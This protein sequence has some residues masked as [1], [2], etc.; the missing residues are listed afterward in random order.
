VTPFDARAELDAAREVLRREN[1]EGDPL[2]AARHFSA[3]VDGILRRTFEPGPPGV[4]LIALGGYG[5]E[6]LAPFSDIDILILRAPDAETAP[7]EAFVRRLWDMRLEPSTVVRTI[8]ETFAAMAGDDHTATTVLESRWIAGDAAL[9]RELRHRSIQAFLREHGAAYGAIKRGRLA[10]SMEACERM[11]IRGEPKIKEGPAGL[12]DVQR[13]LWIE[14]ARGRDGTLAGLDA[15][16]LPADRVEALRAAY[17]FLM[18]VRCELHLVVGLRQDTLE[19]P[20]QGPIAA[21]LGFAPQAE[22]P[23]EE[24]L[25]E[26]CVR[27]AREIHRAGRLYLEMLEDEEAPVPAGAARILQ[28]GVVLAGG[29][30]RARRPRAARSPLEPAEILEPFLVAQEN[31]VELTPGA[32]EEIRLRAAELPESLADEPE[33]A[34]FFLEMAR[35]PGFG[36]AATALAETGLLGRILPAFRAIV[37]RIELDEYHEYPVDEHTLLALREVDRLASQADHEEPGIRAAWLEIRRPEILRLAV[38]FHDIGKARPG[39]HAA[40]GGEIAELACE[41]L[42]LD[43]RGI[44]A[45]RFLVHHHLEM[46]HTAQRRDFHERPAI[47]AFAGLVEDVERLRALYILTYV[48]I[49]SVAG[50]AWTPWKSVELARLFEATRTFLAA[51]SLPDPMR[52]FEEEMARRDL[53]GAERDRLRRHVASLGGAR[54]AR[55]HRLETIVRHADLCDR[56]GSGGAAVEYEAAREAAEVAVAA[57]DR[58]RLFADL[59]GLLSAQG[60]TILSAR[61]HSRDDGVALD[62]FHVAPGDGLR[63]PVEDRLRAFRKDLAAIEAGTTTVERRLADARRRI[64]FRPRRAPRHPPAIRFDADP[65]AGATS[66]EIAAADRLGLLHDLASALSGQGLDIRTARVTTLASLAVDTFYV[67]DRR[68]RRVDDPGDRARIEEALRAAV[69]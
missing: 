54:Y 7:I 30:V 32:C 37:G 15:S 48:D 45:V 31:G 14:R 39:P 64:R 41:R 22:R 23:A 60:L 29:A 28:A 27:H 20:A 50:R 51:G 24:L 3:A 40:T 53:P 10:E 25:V 12:R 33:A 35:R 19:F 36:R 11:P 18:R 8:D 59:V 34:R 2:D 46:N 6:E 17:R 5:R 55:E 4:A 66:I 13:I 68:G 62:I 44:A 16:G 65:S 58:P 43:R 69:G 21:A 56:I 42:G 63:I 61:V 9:D 1:R 38:L 49:R 57:R 47:E 52:W 67:L 26:A